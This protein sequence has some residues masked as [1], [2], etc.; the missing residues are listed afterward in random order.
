VL[1]EPRLVGQI[2]D[3]AVTQAAYVGAHHQ[4]LQQSGADDAA[5]VGDDAAH[6]ADQ[7]AAHLR[8]LD[9]QRALGGVDA[10]RPLPVAPATRLERAL[11]PGPVQETRDLVLDG[12]LQ[13]ELGTQATELAERSGSPTPSSNT[14]SICWTSRSLAATLLFTA[15]LLCGSSKLPLWRLRR[16]QLFQQLWGVTN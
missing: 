5:D 11:V 16:L 6:E 8:H 2:L 14:C 1:T 7:A 4:R 12:P 15:Y 9:R 10:A 13:D 3:V